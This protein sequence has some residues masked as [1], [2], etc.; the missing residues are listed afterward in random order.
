MID[1]IE[2][3][4][5]N[6][7]YIRDLNA[8]H[9]ALGSRVTGAL[10]LSDLLRSQ[11]VMTISALDHYIHEISRLG[12]L[13]IFEGKRSATDSFRRFPVS[14]DG[15]ITC[16]SS[17]NSGWLD[18]EIRLRHGY[19]SFQQPDKIADAIRYFSTMKLWDE[20]GVKLGMSAKDVK[21]K[22][23]LIVGRRN[24]IAHEA[25]VVPGFTGTRWPISATDANDLTNFIEK[26]V[27]AIHEVVA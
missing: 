10:D 21:K 12:I 19:L 2:Q 16:R 17:S 20:V 3:F 22:I 13:E 15:A 7:I 23:E 11:I 14:L 26:V 6:M 18:D 8:L 5:K 4:R 25:D 27:E 24:Q 1:A 9:T